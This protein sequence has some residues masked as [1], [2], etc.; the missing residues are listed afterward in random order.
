MSGLAFKSRSK[1]SN[2][3]FSLVDLPNQVSVADFVQQ[4]PR[5]YLVCPVGLFG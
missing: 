5:S 3:A 2:G 1:L 4:R